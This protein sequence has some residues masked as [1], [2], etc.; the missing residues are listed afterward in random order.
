MAEL[1]TDARVVV[2]GGGAVGA[3]ILWHLTEAGWTDCVLL[4]KNELTAGST[5]HAAGNCPTFSTD[6]A[7]MSIQH[8][9]TTLYRELGERVDYP[10]NYHVS[11]A[12]RLAHDDRRMAEFAKVRAMGHRRDMA[13]EMMDLDA[14]MA[15]YPFTETHDLA[16]ALWDPVDGD[17]DPSQLTQAFAKGARD[18]GARILRFCPAKGVRRED[19]R[20]VVEHEKGEITC[21]IVVNAAGYY[22]GRVGEWFEPFGGRPVPMAVMSHQYMLTDEIPEIGEWTAQNGGKLPILRDVDTSYYLRQEKTGY[23]LGPYER[24]C[25]AHWTGEGEMPDDFSFQL[26]P[27]DLDRLEF[28]IEDA[29]ARV[30]KLGEA[31]MSKVINGPIPY[32]PD[33]LP[34]LGPMP[35]VPNAFEATAFTFGIAQAGGAGKVLADWITKGRPEW[36]CFSVDPRRFTDYT[37]RQYCIDKAMETYGH[38]FAMHF[39]H[40]V[41]PAGRDRKLTPLHSRLKE[42]GA[43]FGPYGGWERATWFAKPGD[44]TSESAT[45]TWRRDGPWQARIREEVGAVRDGVGM[46]DLTGFARFAVDGPGADAWLDGMIAGRLPGPGRVT[47][48]YVCDHDGGVLTEFSVR[49]MGEGF[50]LITAAGAEWHDRDLLM[51]RLP[52]DGSVTIENRTRDFATLLVTGPEARAVLEPMTEG[53]LALPWLSHQRAVVAGQSVDLL[54]VSFAGE[55]GWEIHANPDALPPVWDALHAAGAVPFGMYALNAMRLEKGYAAWKAEL[56]PDY[57]AAE[58]GLGRFVAT[59]K[60]A[61]FPGKAALTGAA[62]ARKLVSLIVE[63]SDMDAPV[64]APV[65][66][67]GRVVGEVTSAAYGHRVD[68]AIALAMVDADALGGTLTVDV[69]GVAC[70]A[71]VQPST[72]LWDAKNERLRA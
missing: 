13:L 69:F 18:A 71:N 6:W 14:L 49:R 31:G 67:G 65:W 1:P 2:I 40:H 5:W 30:P 62:P 35:G 42:A 38:E 46:L 59:G 23:N 33:G 11:G 48:G 15:S 39:P 4:E 54:R 68:A 50:E 63:G 51:E 32:A 41:W 3:S 29:M 45:Q 56:S 25:Q 9:S 58:L 27:D 21:D 16:G 10:I 22:A 12:V 53:D 24:N 64:G 34:L 20:W 60:D 19:G 72:C 57:T 37:D 52:K 55:L 8:Y 17:I 47:L 26:Y 44:D 7:I 61:D 66:G 28:Y 43:Q 70:A 36:D